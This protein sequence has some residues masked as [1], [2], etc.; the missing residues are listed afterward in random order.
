M[1]V[2]YPIMIRRFNTFTHVIAPIISVYLLG[3]MAHEYGHLN[4]YRGWSG[5]LYSG[6]MRALACLSL[7][8]VCWTVAQWLQNIRFKPLGKVLLS[9]IEIGCYALVVIGANHEKHKMFG[10]VMVALLAIGIT[11]TFS[12]KS[13]TG[14]CFDCNLCYWLGNFSL[15]VYLNHIIIRKI[16]QKNDL[17]MSYKKELLIFVAV[18]LAW[19]LV[20]HIIM[21]ILMKQ[22]AKLGEKLKH[23]L[24]ETEEVAPR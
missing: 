7:G 23:A 13:L 1:F 16:F 5:H 14:T 21:K 8:A 18:T 24:V 19:S 12:K 11:I 17:G 2:L 3:W 15:T 6:N 20:A 10:F 22:G 4:H 9:L